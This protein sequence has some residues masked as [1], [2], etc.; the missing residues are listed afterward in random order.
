M[1]KKWKECNGVNGDVLSVANR[2][3]F[4]ILPNPAFPSLHLTTTQP[5]GT[6]LLYYWFKSQCLPHRVGSVLS[7]SGGVD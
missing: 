7:E 1:E 6:V 3:P 5:S 2:R 4:Q